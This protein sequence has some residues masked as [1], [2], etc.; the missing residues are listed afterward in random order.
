MGV[1][2]AAVWWGV[3]CGEGGAVMVVNCTIYNFNAWLCME[4]ICMHIY[5]HAYIN[6]YIHM[7][8]ANN[9]VSNLNCS[10]NE[11]DSEMSSRVT[12]GMDV[13]EKGSN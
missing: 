7:Y 13:I 3:A 2:A 8:I 11:S 6:I 9:S 12:A 10:H 1:A 4:I 5:I